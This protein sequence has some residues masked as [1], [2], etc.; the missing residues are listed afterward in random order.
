MENFLQGSGNGRVVGVHFHDVSHHVPP[1]LGDGIDMSGVLRTTLA[2][3]LLITEKEVGVLVPENTVVADTSLL[4]H[5]DQLRPDG[6][7]AAFVLHL[8]TRLEL[9]LESKSFHVLVL[10]YGLVERHLDDTELP[11]PA[12]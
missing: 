7:V 9:H 8:A 12:D 11:Y 5:I 2:A 3:T 1:P 10:F 6:C 4:D